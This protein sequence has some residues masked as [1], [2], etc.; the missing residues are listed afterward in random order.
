MLPRWYEKGGP[1]MDGSDEM[2]MGK[3]AAPDDIER[4]AE[5]VEAA[6][7]ALSQGDSLMAKGKYR[8]AIARW[9]AFLDAA[10]DLDTEERRPFEERIAQA[11]YRRSRLSLKEGRIS[12]K[13][14]ARGMARIRE[15]HRWDQ[16]NAVYRYQ[17]GLCYWRMG[18]SVRAAEWFERALNGEGVTGSMKTTWALA[19]LTT[20]EAKRALT[21]LEDLAAIEAEEG[22]NEA[23][24]RRLRALAEASVGKPVEALV[25]LQD[26]VKEAPIEALVH[27][28]VSIARSQVP[29]KKACEAL[30]DLYDRIIAV[31][32][33]EKGAP[34][35]D[36]LGDMYARLN[37]NDQAVVWWLKAWESSGNYSIIDKLVASCI[38][39][40][41]KAVAKREFREA[42][43]WIQL[44]RRAK[45][46]DPTLSLWGSSI[47]LLKGNLQWSQGQSDQAVQTWQGVLLTEVGHLAAW[48]LAVAADTSQRSDK[49]ERWQ[50]A[51]NRFK[52]GEGGQGPQ[53]LDAMKHVGSLLIGEGR[54]EEASTILN[55]ALQ[56]Q[57]TPQLRLALGITSLIKGDGHQGLRHLEAAESYGKLDDVATLA[58]A[59]G[60]EI[61][62]SDLSVKVRHWEKACESSFDEDICRMWRQNALELGQIHWRR[63]DLD[64]A[65]NHFA[66]V[67]LKD[68]RHTDGWIWCATIHLQR[69][70]EEKAKAC[71]DEALRNDPDSADTLIKIGGRVLMTQTDEKAMKYFQSALERWPSPRTE[72][73]I[74]EVC[75]EWGRTDLAM[76]RLKE[77]IR[78]CKKSDSELIRLLHF[79]FHIRQGDDIRPILHDAVNVAEQPVR[80][81][82]LLAF[83]HIR[84]GDW[85]GAKTVLDQVKKDLASA[86][87]DEVVET[88]E[89]LNRT[90]I[91]KMTIGTVDEEQFERRLNQ[92]VTG[93]ALAAGLDSDGEKTAPIEWTARLEPLLRTLQKSLAKSK[94]FELQTPGL[95][96]DRKDDVL[97]NLS[98]GQPI[99]FEG[100]LERAVLAGHSDDWV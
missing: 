41:S 43:R 2:N 86:R 67:L 74:A 73:R 13:A 92:L 89:Y 12:R 19:M 14:L 40:A 62:G 60:H 64:E 11:Y 80:I 78:R 26:L 38:Q 48:N 85:H 61:I 34:L 63:G 56:L 94:A 71:F 21:V 55:R 59:I 45:D 28:A 82:L 27:E 79:L 10:G 53:A 81:R 6:K 24:I 25:M 39:G 76:E 4:A 57:E 18:N 22:G 75:G 31:G 23:A 91:M 36:V 87:D 50:E 84:G 29:S 69:G 51:L 49:I 35:A 52:P 77:G 83:E 98:F 5:V 17:I 9:S 15:A 66:Q 54:Y 7:D 16:A 95:Q 88:A 90:M 68:P 99:R 8:A 3:R 42:E 96:I 72:R 44:G 93:W 37:D 97:N 32:A 30:N 1:A 33:H 65:M 58:Q 100:M 20:G 70:D 46:E 47:Q